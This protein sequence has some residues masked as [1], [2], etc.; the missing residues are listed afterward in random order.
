MG[1]ANSR[2][3]VRCHQRAVKGSRPLRGHAGSTQTGN[4]EYIPEPIPH[5]SSS[6]TRQSL[7][8]KSQTS[9]STYAVTNGGVEFLTRRQYS[10]DGSICG[11]EDRQHNLRSILLFLRR[12]GFPPDHSIPS[13]VTDNLEQWDLHE[14]TIR[15]SDTFNSATARSQS[16][17]RPRLVCDERRQSPQSG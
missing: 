11:C 14:A 8:S 1:N 17:V 5:R 16:M 4:D 3:C 12:G 9:L 10:I 13:Q 2:P 15:N 7:S 6:G